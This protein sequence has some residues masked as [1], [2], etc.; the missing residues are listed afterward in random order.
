MA[1]NTTKTIH[2]F[3]INMFIDKYLV[4]ICNVVYNKKLDSWAIVCYNFSYGK[5]FV[6]ELTKHQYE[7][8]LLENMKIFQYPNQDWLIFDGIL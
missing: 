7:E 4:N 8:I 1:E 2:C 5:T 6:C 3:S